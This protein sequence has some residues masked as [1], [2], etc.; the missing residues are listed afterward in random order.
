MKI[1]AAM[2]TQNELFDLEHNVGRLLE[3]MDTVTVVDGGSLDGTIPYM[4]NWARVD[5][6]V[7]FFIHPWN[8]NFP[9]QRN[10]YI[11]RVR[12]I[13]EP[14]DYL[15]ACDPDELL[16]PVVEG[17]AWREELLR[18]AGTGVGTGLI[19]CRSV[20][21]RGPLRAWE[22]VDEY[23]KPLFLKLTPE[24]GYGHGGAMPV[25]ET[26][27]GRAPGECRLSESFLYEHRKQEN[28]IWPRGARNYFCGGGGPNLGA[29]NHRWVELRQ[30]AYL[31][32]ITTWT[33]MHIALLKGDLHPSLKAWIIKYRLEDGWDGSSEQREWYKTYF[34]MYHPEEEPAE[35]RGEHIP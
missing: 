11:A 13:A 1:H 8:D 30:I 4:R 23:H 3:I 27:Y 10:N 20:S 18:V 22:N 28:V 25:H 24:L 17:H 2:M 7:R 9:A 34:R 19:R 26:L 5:E 6:R 15:F 29:T 16:D 33:Q 32:E 21:Y 14:G 35:L 31:Q 12:E